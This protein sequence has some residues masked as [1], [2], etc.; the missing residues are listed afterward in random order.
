MK[1]W[2]EAETKKRLI[3]VT[4]C[5]LHRCG[6]V[7]LRLKRRIKLFTFGREG[8]EGVRCWES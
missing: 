1:E 7:T 4:I 6:T 8:Q 2:N 3:L 5:P